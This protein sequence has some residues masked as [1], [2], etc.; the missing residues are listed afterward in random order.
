MRLSVFIPQATFQQKPATYILKKPP[1]MRGSYLFLDDVIVAP[2]GIAVVRPKYG[3]FLHIFFMKNK[4]L[5]YNWEVPKKFV[6]IS[7]FV[8]YHYNGSVI[9]IPVKGNVSLFDP[10]RRR[11]S[12]HLNLDRNHC[13]AR[14]VNNRRS[15]VCLS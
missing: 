4:D 1:L 5:N 6:R 9:L 2:S 7:N 12:G 15:H 11:I 13:A 3:K 14:S 10:E 8:Y